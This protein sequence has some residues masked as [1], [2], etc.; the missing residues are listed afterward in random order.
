MNHLI[1][2]IEASRTACLDF[3][4]LQFDQLLEKVKSSTDFLADMNATNDHEPQGEYGVSMLVQAAE[5]TPQI[6]SDSELEKALERPEPLPEPAN[7]NLDEYVEQLKAEHV[8]NGGVLQTL[9]EKF[10][11]EKTG[12][13]AL[14]SIND[15][16]WLSFVKTIMLAGW[17]V[18]Q[19][20]SHKSCQSVIFTKSETELLKNLE[21]LRFSMKGKDIDLNQALG[22]DWVTPVEAAIIKE[23]A[24]KEKLK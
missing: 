19:L 23:F 10:D 2:F 7:P 22:Q 9:E 24:Q 13:T 12:E 4:N 18:E 16:Q 11:L 15:K 20:K 5:E 8:A 21:C 6:P 14:S 1:P 17:T 3:V